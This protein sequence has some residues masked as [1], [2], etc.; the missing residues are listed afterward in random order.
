MGTASPAERRMLRTPEAAQ[1][2]GLSESQLEKWRQTRSGPPF[3][4]FGRAIAYDQQDLDR[5]IADQKVNAFGSNG[6][7][8]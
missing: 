8:A 5:W 4:R 2:L 7:E 6:G 3:A 1:Y